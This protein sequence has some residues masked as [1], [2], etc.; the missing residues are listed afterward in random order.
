MSSEGPPTTVPTAPTACSE[1]EGG[2][3]NTAPTE[4]TTTTKTAVETTKTTPAVETTKTTPAVTAAPPATTPAVATVATVAATTTAAAA[5]TASAVETTKASAVTASASASAPTTTTTT[6]ATTTATTAAATKPA[7]EA[8]STV[9]SQTVGAHEVSSKKNAPEEKANGVREQTGV[10]AAKEGLVVDTPIVVSSP[11]PNLNANAESFTPV[12]ASLQ[13]SL[14]TYPVTP[15][16]KVSNT[17]NRSEMRGSTSRNI[18]HGPPLPPPPPPPPMYPASMMLPALIPNMPPP[19]PPP[20]PPSATPFFVPPPGMQPPPSPLMPH[21]VPNLAG[22][23]PPPPPPPFMPPPPPPSCGG[24]MSF[25]G[26][27]GVAMSSMLMA[28]GPDASLLS[29][30]FP[31]GSMG[32]PPPPPPT[33]MPPPPLQQQQLQQLGLVPQPQGVRVSVGNAT[34]AALVSKEP[35]KFSCVLLSGIPGVG[36]TTM[37]REL[38][39]ELKRDGLG[40]VFF[41]GADFLAGTTAKR[42]AWETTKEVFDAL[43]KRLD[44]LLEQQKNERNVKGLV[45]DKNVKSI[46]DI[47]YLA[48][49][50]KAR[51]IPFVGIVGMEAE[52]DDVLL[53]RMGGGEELRE[54]LKYHRV[55]H[56]RVRA[57]AKRAGMYRE[58]DATKSME[59]VL[60]SLRTMVLGCCAQPP[61]RGIRI[62]LYGDSTATAMV[63]NHTEF[64]DVLTK[65]FDLVQTTKGLVPHYPG[66]ADFTP[67]STR[68]MTEKNRVS[69]IKSGYGVRRLNSGGRHLL[70][71]HNGSLHLIPTHLKAV[72]RMP[73]KAWLGSKLDTV[74][75]FVLEGD[76]VR[77]NKDRSGEK[78]L[79]FDALFWSNAEHP[80]TNEVM[81]MNWAERQ[82]FLATHLPAEKNA[83]FPSGT[84]CI[85]VHQATVKL[86]EIRE[87]LESS[88]YPSEGIVFQPI[89]AVNTYEKVYVWRPPSS[90]TVDFRIGALKSTTTDMIVSDGSIKEGDGVVT[91]SINSP[92]STSHFQQQQQQ[93]QQQQRLSS[94]LSLGQSVSS[95]GGLGRSVCQDNIP[96]RTFELEV[97]DKYEKEYTQFEDGTVEVRNPDV[98]EGC[99]CSCVLAD[100]KKHTWT[101]ERIRY[102]AL[103]PAYKRDVVTLLENC[104]IP[105]AKLIHWLEHEKIIP[106][107]PG[108]TP[109]MQPIIPGSATPKSTATPTGTQTH[110]G[111]GLP[112]YA[113]AVMMQHGG[114]PGTVPMHM[115]PPPPVTEKSG[116]QTMFPR[117]SPNRMSSSQNS[118]MAALA[119][120]VYKIHGPMNAATEPRTK[121]PHTKPSSTGDVQPLSTLELLTTMVPSVHIVRTD[122]TSE[123]HKSNQK[124]HSR[125]Q[126]DRSEQHGGRSMDEK[127]GDE[128]GGNSKKSS[129]HNKT[130]QSGGQ[131]NTEVPANCAQCSKKQQPEDL[132]LDKRDQNYYC[133][134]CW[135]KLGWEFCRECN[136]FKEGYRERTRRRV[137]DFYCNDCWASFNK[138]GNGDKKRADRASKQKND[139]PQQKQ[140]DGEPHTTTTTTAA[141]V[142]SNEVGEKS[143]SARRRRAQKKP[144]NKKKKKSA[145]DSA[146]DLHNAEEGGAPHSESK[147]EGPAGGK[148]KGRS[149]RNEKRSQ[150]GPKE[151]MIAERPE[152]QNDVPNDVNV[153]VE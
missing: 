97:Y 44:E 20:P 78:F 45:I 43:Q 14:G 127:G 27:I 60:N 115:P 73:E 38:V 4:P 92:S 49:L 133:Y 21:F 26:P 75:S 129:R 50:L 148:Q 57:L 25:P 59:E 136:E 61:Q 130:H 113:S 48:A 74:G 12:S 29:S 18:Q 66:T 114:I 150:S 102:D 139:A 111:I 146:G 58:I 101:F 125:Q 149:R 79:V 93:Q 140:Q 5:P 77:L 19:P 55:I 9:S 16:R 32:P 96:T 91:S 80:E 51:Q 123:K 137:G 144:Q 109:P 42:P 120:P 121:T 68:E 15:N 76:L 82:A 145:G 122:S 70:L 52:N 31:N 128:K 63:D 89:H 13:R 94:V 106:P 81:R 69:T 3:K 98:V 39:S 85:V 118:V 30:V 54:K 138:D 72:L 90:I 87:M 116:Y 53:K 1:V 151:M 36:K 134:G 71:Y 88:D 83:V 34:L 124:D 141:D 126:R 56:A 103:R 22:V 95:Q 40:W 11:K 152:S 37:G 147:R 99:I 6:T 28:K 62:D 47:Y 135:A 105:K 2:N 33:A 112:T 153:P 35:P 8:S 86:E 143:E 110:H 104:I 41:S 67:F 24:P 84:N 46:E 100:E 7:A 10:P 132:R 117:T 23:P 142:V 131:G 119:D 64:C 17:T 108:N 65:L 107:A